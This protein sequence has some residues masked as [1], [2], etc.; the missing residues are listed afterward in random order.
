[1]NGLPYR[2]MAAVAGVAALALATSGCGGEGASSESDRIKVVTSTN[3][4]GSVAGAVGGDRVEVD[5]L[6]DDPVA[7]PHS[8]ESTATDGLAVAESKLV[9][10]NGGG[11]DDFAAKLA[12]QSEGVPAIDAFELSGHGEE[13]PEDEHAEEDEHAA[14]EG[15]H[16]DEDGHGHGG[17][18]EHVWY[19]LETVSK[20]ADEVANQLGEIDP[21][22]KA[23]FA[24]NAT[25]FKA[26]L[27]KLADRLAKLGD[28]GKVKALATEPV[29]H[30]LLETAG[31]TDSTPEA[32]SEAIEGETDVPVAAQEEVNQLIDAQRIDVL[33]N[34]PQTEIDLTNQLVNRAGKAGIPVVEISETLP[35]GTSEYVAWI[36]AAVDKLEA[37]VD[38]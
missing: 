32:F 14:E 17:A 7:D 24:A 38:G 12:K 16:A 27:D 11:Y 8:Y 31:I 29:A 10:F 9:V 6:I 35:E 1:M 36:D 26:E 37:A 4:W 3:V 22:G 33:V 34:N 21:S 15:E 20:V 13:D 2:R 25:A 30:Y 18:N 28:H 5:S 19:D 23:E